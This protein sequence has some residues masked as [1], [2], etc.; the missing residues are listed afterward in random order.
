MVPHMQ[1]ST[2]CEMGRYKFVSNFLNLFVTYF[3]ISLF[4]ALGVPFPSS[5]IMISLVCPRMSLQ[6]GGGGERE[7]DCGILLVNPCNKTNETAM[8]LF[9][10]EA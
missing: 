6:E 8:K 9:F 2:N 7:R 10:W 4:T 3:Y 1:L 5:C